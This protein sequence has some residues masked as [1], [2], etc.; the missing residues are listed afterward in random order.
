[1]RLD[2][3]AKLGDVVRFD[4]DIILKKYVG[5]TTY[6]LAD[7]LPENIASTLTAVAR[8]S[9]T[10]VPPFAFRDTFYIDN[11][12]LFLQ[13]KR[14]I[15]SIGI[16]QIPWGTGYA[17]NPTDLWNIKDILDPT[18]EKP[19][20]PSIK[21]EHGL[22]NLGVIGVVGFDE[23]WRHIPWTA[24][25]ATHA[26]G[27][28]ISLCAGSNVRELFD[29][30]LSASS[31]YFRR[32]LSGYAVSGQI[33]DIGVWS[34]GALNR[35]ETDKN[36]VSAYSEYDDSMQVLL[37]FIRHLGIDPDA[38]ETDYLKDRTFA[39][40]LAGMDYTFG[41]GNGLHC[42]AEYLYNGDGKD[43]YDKYSLEDWLEYYEG[44]NLSLGMHMLFGGLSFSPTDLSTVSLYAIGN[45]SDRSVM[46]NPWFTYSITDDSELNVI[47]AVPVGHSNDEFG[48]K[49]Y[50]GM[51]RLK[52]YW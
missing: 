22:G 5:S 51:V 14:T 10:R 41:I 23:N 44:L 8:L 31:F 19:G 26:A 38:L 9:G 40:L 18:Y 29:P 1:L 52:I 37:P 4:G 15:F 27:F 28:D 11:A 24:S 17:F 12:A 50:T 13:K 6:D 45:L 49:V 20:K 34:E 21:F 47:G 39:Q 2:L 36:Y 30:A 33:G 32:Y 25:L 3:K 7:Y 46:I 42:M 48:Q 43:D 35:V 16:Q